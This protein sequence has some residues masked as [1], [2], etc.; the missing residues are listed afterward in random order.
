MRNR[1]AQ[2]EGGFS[3]IEVLIVLAVA[4]VI[5]T[6]GFAYLIGSRPATLLHQA[7]I[8]LSSDLSLSRDLAYNEESPV[9]VVFDV[10]NDWYYTEQ[11]DTATGDWNQVGVY[12]YLPDGINL[13]DVTF[14]SDTVSFTPRG[15]LVVGGSITITNTK[16]ATSVLNG[17]I[18][19]GRFPILGGALR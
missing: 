1:R 12:K 17:V 4:A 16:G 8:Q 19:T 2:N 6:M 15:T 7:E 9:R 18:P 14:P 10:A 13:S 3:L 11:Q 5:A